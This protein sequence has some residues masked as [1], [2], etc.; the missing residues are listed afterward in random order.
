[1]ARP[2]DDR[3]PRKIGWLLVFVVLLTLTILGIIYG[4]A[5]AEQRGKAAPSIA[6]A[7]AA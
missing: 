5:R 6:T 1:M 4:C 3:A 2:D 7:S